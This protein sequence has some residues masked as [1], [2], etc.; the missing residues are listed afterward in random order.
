M[1]CCA[2]ASSQSPLYLGVYCGNWLLCLLI[3]TQ[4]RSGRM[5]AA[6]RRRNNL[7]FFR[8]MRLC[9]GL[10][11][12]ARKGLSYL[13]DSRVADLQ[14]SGKDT[15]R[16]FV[17]FFPSSSLCP[18]EAVPVLFVPMTAATNRAPCT[19]A[20]GRLAPRVSSRDL[21]RVS[22]TSPRYPLFES[23]LSLLPRQAEIWELAQR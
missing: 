12:R 21:E 8:Y 2:S 14:H 4:F 19:C 15:G 18:S 16:I 5:T 7:L 3:I 6:I 23:I 1:R 17:F 13:S 20:L 11:L 10:G 22:G 9:T